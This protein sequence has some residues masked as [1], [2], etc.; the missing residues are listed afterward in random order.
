MH[1]RDQLGK[2]HTL[3]NKFL[4]KVHVDTCTRASDHPWLF[5]IK[6]I[7]PPCTVLC[8]ILRP[9]GLKNHIATV[10]FYCQNKLKQAKHIAIVVQFQW[11]GGHWKEENRA[12]SAES[13][14]LQKSKVATY[15]RVSGH[16][17]IFSIW[18]YQSDLLCS[19]S[20]HTNFELIWTQITHSYSSN[21]SL[22]SAEIGIIHRYICPFSAR[23][24]SLK[25]ESKANIAVPSEVKKSKSAT[26]THVSGTWHIFSMWLNQSDLLCSPSTH[27]NFELIW[28]K[29]AHSYSSNLS[30]NSAETGI[31]HRYICPFSAR[32]TS[33]ERGKQGQH[34]CAI[35][36]QKF[37]SGHLHV[38][39]WPLTIF[40]AQSGFYTLYS[41]PANFE[42]IWTSF[43]HSHSSFSSFWTLARVSVWPLEDFHQLTC[44]VWSPIFI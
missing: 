30:L 19:P 22:N 33:L 37:K 10:H 26:N 20:T 8:Q 2:V 34:S 21:L 11:S 5:L 35:R 39:Q 1:I 28:T 6:V 14:N 4:Q 17:Q 16:W 3:H 27:T 40:H 25:E 13:S 32:K 31:T 42:L 9:F 7:C 15:T 44:P 41:A 38:C 36:S 43:G 18:L 12:N 24:T 29:F 23:K